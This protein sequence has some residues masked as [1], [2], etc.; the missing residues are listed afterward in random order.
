M[1]Y[2]TLL[3]INHLYCTDEYICCYF[4]YKLFFFFGATYQVKINMIRFSIICHK[5]LVIWDSAVTIWEGI[6]HFKWWS[7]P[8]QMT[9]NV[10][11]VSIV[12]WEAVYKWK[13]YFNKYYPSLFLKRHRPI[14]LL[15]R[16]KIYFR[17]FSHLSVRLW[18]RYNLL[19]VLFFRHSTWTTW[20]QLRT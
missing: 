6:T 17:F 5:T 8:I 16:N 18:S 9:S 20:R 11:L 3:N 4:G 10:E 15:E 12:Q 13:L 19:D 14:L 1:R 2:W 7:L